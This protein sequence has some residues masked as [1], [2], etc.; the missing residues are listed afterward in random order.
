M[1]PLRRRATPQ[2]SAATV[3]VPVGATITR[4]FFSPTSLTGRVVT[5]TDGR[6]RSLYPPADVDVG[7]TAVVETDEGVVVVIT[8]RKANQLDYELYRHVGLDLT[9]RSWC[10]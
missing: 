1:N 9:R 8:T 2:A 5:L 4:Q 6:F 10:R 7:P 3:T